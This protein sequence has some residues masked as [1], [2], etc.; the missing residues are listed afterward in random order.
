M[1]D[2]RSFTDYQPSSELNNL[3]Q[4]RYAIQNSNDYR[5]FLQEQGQTLMKEFSESSTEQECL[6]C[7]VCKK[8]VSK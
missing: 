6:L 1:S 3:I 8:P 2:G 7:P 4:R 5:K